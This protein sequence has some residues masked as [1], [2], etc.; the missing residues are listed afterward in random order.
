MSNEKFEPGSL[1]DEAYLLY[2]YKTPKEIEA[3]NKWIREIMGMS[4][5]TNRKKTYFYLP[6]PAPYNGAFGECRSDLYY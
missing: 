2:E 4:R 1:M 3:S 5:G 6:V